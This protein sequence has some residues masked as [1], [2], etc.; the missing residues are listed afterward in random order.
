M[1]NRESE[2]AILYEI[3]SVSKRLHSL[4]EIIKLTLDKSQRLIGAEVSVFYLGGQEKDVL[5]A[6]AS[7]GIRLSRVLPCIPLQPHDPIRVTTLWNVPQEFPFPVDPLLDTYPVQSALGVPIYDDH[8]VLAWLYVARITLDSFSPG[9]VTLYNVLADQVASSLELMI[10]R[11]HEQQQQEILMAANQ[12]LEQ[13]LDSLTAAY[14]RQEQLIQTINQLS[15]PILPVGPGVLLMPLIGLVDHQRSEQISS[16]ILEE[17]ARQRARVIILDITAL[18]AMDEEV[19]QAFLNATHAV[20]LLGARVV[21]TGIQPP[22]AQTL[23]QLGIDLHGIQTYS[24]LQEGIASVLGRTVG[25]K[26]ACPVQ[27]A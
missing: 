13:T 25:S 15:A 27:R 11:E 2:L 21:L 17:T 18:A 20:R 7:R 3:A 14:E 9:E 23:V 10:A 26:E 19:G 5:C 8:V 6:Y 12:Q 1:L 22:I 16:A 24:T 4:D